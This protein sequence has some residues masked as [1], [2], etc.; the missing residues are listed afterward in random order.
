MLSLPGGP[1]VLTAG[2][3]SE[4]P[5]GLGVP[6]TPLPLTLLQELTSPRLIK[7]H[8]PYRFLPSDLHNGDSKVRPWALRDRVPPRA[9][10]GV[11]S[12]VPRGPGVV[13]PW[14]RP[15]LSL[16]VSHLGVLR[17]EVGLDQPKSSLCLLKAEDSR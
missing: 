10:V 17:V 16:R 6:R 1:L 13:R 2:P 7:S 8:L 11:P 5:R 14:Y 12:S 15:P 4:R 9:G 3:P